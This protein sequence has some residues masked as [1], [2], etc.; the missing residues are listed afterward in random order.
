MEHQLYE[1][2][3]LC[4]V[5]VLITGKKGNGTG[6]FVAPR[7]ILTCAHVLKVAQSDAPQ[8][9]VSWRGGIYPGQITKLLQDEDL[10]LLQV[11]L[12]DHPCVYLHEE[13]IP[14]DDLYSFGYPDDH[15]NGDP[16]TFSLE[17]RGGEQ[18]EQLK[19]KAGQVRPGMSGAPLLNVRTC[20]VCGVVQLTRDRNNDLGGREIPTTT[21][22]QVFPEL[23]T[24][25]QQFH[26][27]DTRWKKYL[28]KIVAHP[29][30]L[31]DHPR[32]YIPF[33]RNPLFQARPGEFEQLEGLLFKVGT[34]QKSRRIGLVGVGMV[35]MGGIGKTQLAIE[36]AYRYQQYFPSGVF[37][38]SATGK[39]VFDWHRPLAELAFNTGYLPPDDDV[40]SP[41]NELR[42]AQHFCRYLAR[43]ENA[44]LI[45]DNVEDTNLVISAL[46]TLAGG[47]L[48]CA[49]LYT[50]RSRVGPN[51][52]ITYQVKQLSEEGALRLLLEDT[53]PS[54]LANILARDQ[55]A[56]V[57]A[58]RK[59][60]QGVGYLPLALVH[61][62]SLL[63][64]D[65]N[66][67]LVRLAEVLKQR[68]ALDIAKT[69][70]SDVK[71]LFATF[72][73]SW[74]KVHDEEARRL[75]KLA[76][77]FPEA[78]PIPLLLLGLAAGLGESGEIFE[79]LGKACAQLQDLSL[80][81]ILVGN[82]IQLHPLVREFGQMLVTEDGDKGRA[83]LV[84]AGKQLTRELTDLNKLERWARREG[85][86]RC[87]EQV[88]AAHEYI[89]LLG[90]SQVEQLK[91]VERC[92]DREGYLLGDREWEWWPKLFPGL[93]YQQL[94]NR[95]AEE[96]HPLTGEVPPARWLR[97]IG[98]AGT[99][100]QS[101]RR[102]FAGHWGIVSMHSILS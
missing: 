94:Y 39:T 22:F 27:Q 61:L 44:L 17:G 72:W 66:L 55:D 23:R 6:F 50:S 7:L 46:P 65:Q 42:R 8:I 37:W 99:E 47:E 45:L 35:G 96:N 101:L 76:S 5:R 14:F 82:Q 31:V 79:P 92:L 11:N 80:I 90:T 71:P 77:Y 43:H 57:H 87:L 78:A 9:E 18:G 15:S 63:E 21:V 83:L 73:L 59:V 75:F 70:Y 20:H 24:Q 54:L 34:D 68:G 49:I 29:R 33:P 95:S 84:R 1:L 56:E 60:C 81:E 88:R 16:A 40:S 41:E 30:P 85:Y 102:L 12:S 36:L 91:W 64:R 51:G 62:R 13:A 53:R 58:A 93:F 67:R 38:M 2:L 32:N 25:Q 3:R 89:E 97:Q 4:T 69:L 28:Y 74:E 100:D 48:T 98:Q 52:V 86:W 26:Q 19:F 10:A